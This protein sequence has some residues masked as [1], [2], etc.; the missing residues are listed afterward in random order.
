MDQEAFEEAMDDTT[1]G[2]GSDRRNWMVQAMTVNLQLSL[3]INITSVTSLE[4]IQSKEQ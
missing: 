3:K 4:R 2:S 1:D